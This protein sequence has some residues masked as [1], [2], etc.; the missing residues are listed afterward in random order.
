[1]RTAFPAFV[2]C[3]TCLVASGH[4]ALFV[5]WGL[6]KLHEPDAL[7]TIAHCDS[8]S[9]VFRGDEA[10]KTWFDKTSGTTHVNDRRSVPVSRFG[11]AQR[12]RLDLAP[13]GVETV[14]RREVHAR[15]LVDVVASAALDSR[16]KPQGQLQYTGKLFAALHRV[17]W[18]GVP[19]QKQPV[20]AL[21]TFARAGTPH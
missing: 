7:L 12:Q 13:D 1:M 9:S 17:Q 18:T 2:Q 11:R 6:A 3:L 14:R 16:F 15:V 20:C 5:V 19:Q 10:P 8:L 4:C 21:Q